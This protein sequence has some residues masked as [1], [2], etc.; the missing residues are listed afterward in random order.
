MAAGARSACDGPE[1]GLGAPGGFRKRGLYCS[2]F[3]LKTFSVLSSL[4]NARFSLHCCWFI[5]GALFVPERIPTRKTS[6]ARTSAPRAKLVVPAPPDDNPPRTIFL[7]PAARGARFA[8][9]LFAVSF[10]IATSSGPPTHQVAPSVPA[11]RGLHN[12]ARPRFVFPTSCDKSLS[13]L[14]FFARCGFRVASFSACFFAL[15]QMVRKARH[16]SEAVHALDWHAKNLILFRRREAPTT[17][18]SPLARPSRR[19]STT[20][21]CQTGLMS[22]PRTGTPSKERD[23]LHRDCSQFGCDLPCDQRCLCSH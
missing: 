22:Q 11:S 19:R 15:L 20:K 21:M 8:L 10:V 4:Q 14:G 9:T 12:V 1:G 5:Q 16:S 3:L 6:C 7:E 23:S 18:S 13:E 2:M 17:H